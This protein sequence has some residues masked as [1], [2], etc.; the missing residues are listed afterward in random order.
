MDAASPDP[1][2]A[3]RTP[4]K[5][6]TS[7][8]SSASPADSPSLSTNEPPSSRSLWAEEDIPL[9]RLPDAAR[10]SKPPQ[11][12]EDGAP[13]PAR[14]PLISV[15]TL[16]N[17][18][19][20]AINEVIV[21]ELADPSGPIEEVSPTVTILNKL[22]TGMTNGTDLKEIRET[23][24]KI[25][26]H[27]VEKSDLFTSVLNQ[28]D[29]ERTADWILI[30]ALME[31]IVKRAA[32]RGDINSTQA[33]AIWQM[34]NTA[35]SECQSRQPKTKAVDTITVVE[36]VDLNKQELE[37]TIQQRWEG[38]TPQGREIIR[39]K[40]FALKRQLLGPPRADLEVKTAPAQ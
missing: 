21:R 4:K 37:R 20:S 23:L 38:T 36:T 7:A 32:Q 6:P 5:K 29:Q 33:T 9:P 31:K 2:P 3:E 26:A 28:I 39:K 10:R 11:C 13:A 8:T 19:E 22:V 25:A 15:V 18:K 35:I 14:K 27:Q 17:S 34:A 12:A 24:T 1:S 30:R 16:S 40:L